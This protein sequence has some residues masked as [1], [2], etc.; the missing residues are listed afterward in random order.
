[1]QFRYDDLVDIIKIDTGGKALLGAEKYP[2]PAVLQGLAKRPPFGKAGIRAGYHKQG[3]VRQV[4][5]QGFF[6]R[7]QHGN[8]PY[9][10]GNDFIFP[11]GGHFNGGHDLDRGIPRIFLYRVRG[12]ADAQEK[13]NLL[14]QAHHG[15]LSG[16]A[17]GRK[18]IIPH[19]IKFMDC[20]LV[21]FLLFRR[22]LEQHLMDLF[23]ILTGHLFKGP[24]NNGLSQN[25][26]E[27]IRIV[28]ILGALLHAEYGYLF[29]KMGGGK[30]GIPLLIGRDW[31]AEIRIDVIIRIGIHLAVLVVV[32]NILVP[33]NHVDGVVVKQLQLWGKLRNVVSGTGA[34]GEQLHPAAAETR[35]YR[36]APGAVGV[37]NLIALI[38]YQLDVLVKT[39]HVLS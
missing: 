31:L 3:A 26:A 8:M 30:Q 19:F 21:D 20:F 39:F 17:C 12:G 34:C 32:I 16:I 25:I 27:N 38:Q 10:D 22:E 23:D 7:F 35:E 2:V 1:M 14:D 11:F 37:G 33:G 4:F 28:D 6:I 18:I 5:P 13:N 24:C 9:S 36:L 29:R 15:I